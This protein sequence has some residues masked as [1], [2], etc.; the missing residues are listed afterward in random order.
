VVSLGFPFYALLFDFSVGK[1]GKKG[2]QLLYKP[3]SIDSRP[4]RGILP[5]HKRLNPARSY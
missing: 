4:Q 1:E 2:Q 3:P 5:A